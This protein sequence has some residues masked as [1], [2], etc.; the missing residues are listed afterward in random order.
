MDLQCVNWKYVLGD[1]KFIFASGFF[2]FPLIPAK[3]LITQM[4]LWKKKQMT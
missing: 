3:A 1:F 4:V 2:F